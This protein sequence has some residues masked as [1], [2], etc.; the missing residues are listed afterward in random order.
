M[1]TSKPELKVQRLPY[2]PVVSSS[3]QTGSTQQTFAL[4]SFGCN[5]RCTARGVVKPAQT[6]EQT[7]VVLQVS[8][9]WTTV[10][11][12]NL[13]RTVK[14]GNLYNF[15]QNINMVFSSFTVAELL[16]LRGV[17]MSS[18]LPQQI[19]LNLKDLGLTTAR[20]TRRG[21]RGGVHKQRTILAQCSTRHQGL[22]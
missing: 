7:P 22:L 10:I 14:I 21:V 15:G 16:N 2:C 1:E 9:L 12:F 20:P 4:S 18:K 13:I 11:M 19:Y 6:G 8:F 5:T 3:A 17:V